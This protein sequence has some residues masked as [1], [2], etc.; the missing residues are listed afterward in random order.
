[1][2]LKIVTPETRQPVARGETGE[3]LVKGPTLMEGYYK[4]PRGRSFDAEGFFKTGDLGAVDESGYLHFAARLKDVIKTAGIN[5][6]S[7]EVEEALMRHEA[8]EAAYVVGVA[9]SVR[10][11]NIAAFVVLRDGHQATADALREL[12]RGSLASYKVPRHVFTIAA[13]AVPRTGSGKVE[14][15]ALRRE[16]EVRAQARAK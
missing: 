3:I 4:M 16:A 1:M 6:A 13:S 5:V 9:D 2:E 15:A 11:E 7:V 10:G 12:C 14:K 8:V